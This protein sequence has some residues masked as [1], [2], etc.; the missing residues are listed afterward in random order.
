MKIQ[1][2]KTSIYVSYNNQI[3]RPEIHKTSNNLYPITDLKSN[4]EVN[5]SLVNNTLKISTQSVNETWYTT[6][7]VSVNA[8]T[9]EISKSNTVNNQI[10]DAVTTKSKS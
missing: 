4:Q 7:P 2:D 10:T 6:D 8:P 3:F 1:Q 5:V 9:I